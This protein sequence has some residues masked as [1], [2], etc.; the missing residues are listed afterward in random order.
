M[1]NLR[2]KR[3]NIPYEEYTE[4]LIIIVKQKEKEKVFLKR[5]MNE[6]LLSAKLKI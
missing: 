2:G 4:N 1:S 3:G 6:M 5:K